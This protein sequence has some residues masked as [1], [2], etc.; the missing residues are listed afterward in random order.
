MRS[1]SGVDK[2]AVRGALFADAELRDRRLD[3]ARVDAID[4]VGPRRRHEPCILF[5]SHLSPPLLLPPRRVVRRG[6]RRRV[7]LLRE[8]EGGDLECRRRARFLGG[9]LQCRLLLR[10]KPPRLLLLG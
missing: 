8:L 9:A 5:L 6:A 3:V 4:R 2:H 1:R 7:A 10:R